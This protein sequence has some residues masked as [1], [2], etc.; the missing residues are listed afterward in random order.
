[1]MLM[2][3]DI[4]RTIFIVTK[5]ILGFLILIYFDASL[6]TCNEDIPF[7]KESLQ[8]LKDDVKDWQT[9]CSNNTQDY[10]QDLDTP[11]CNAEKKYIHNRRRMQRKLCFYKGNQLVYTHV[12]YK[13]K[14]TV[15]KVP[16]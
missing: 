6:V 2:N 11:C 16:Q 15:Q 4:Q 7:C 10:R 14:S 3:Q 9:R 13:V 12:K 5:V 1:M 8:A